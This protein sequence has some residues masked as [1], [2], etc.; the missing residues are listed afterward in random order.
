MWAVMSSYNRVNGAYASDSRWL[1]TA[2]LKDEWG[3]DGIVMSDWG[4]PT[5]RRRAN[6]G[7]DIEILARRASAATG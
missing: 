2:L 6:A 4:G 1:L 5:H 3:F 7:L